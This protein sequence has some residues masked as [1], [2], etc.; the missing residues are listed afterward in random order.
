[1]D[2][3]LPPRNRS[4]PIDYTQVSGRRGTREGSCHGNIRAADGTAS[5]S[6][7]AIAPVGMVRI[8]KKQERQVQKKGPVICLHLRSWCAVATG[9]E[10]IS[11]WLKTIDCLQNQGACG[12]ADHLEYWC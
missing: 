8:G 5:R 11:V 6:S 9:M 7:L 10:L 1:M 3:D 4:K 2:K 12:L